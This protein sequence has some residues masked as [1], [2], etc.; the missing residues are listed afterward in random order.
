MTVANIRPVARVALC[1]TPE[2]LSLIG[3]MAARP[4]AYAG[5]FPIPTHRTLAEVDAAKGFS[6]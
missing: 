3:A 1:L 6:A 4:S 2:G 5:P